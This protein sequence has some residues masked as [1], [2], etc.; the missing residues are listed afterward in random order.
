MW[1][2]H[3][4]PD[5]FLHFVVNAVLLAGV[6]GCVLFFFVIN[7]LLRWVPALAPYYTIGQVVSAVLL[8]AGV[9]LSGGLATE[10]AWRERVAQVEAELEEAK[11]EAGKVTTVVQE[12][13]VYRN[14]VIKEQGQ[15]LV[16]RVE[17]MKEADCRVPQ[18]AID[19]HNEAARMNKVIEEQRKAKQ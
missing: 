6:V 19:V 15:T 1:I 11:K 17:V 5:G 16:Q 10:D 7:R 18:E 4:L 2:L 3:F 9:Y 13:V 12:K 14:R 8:T